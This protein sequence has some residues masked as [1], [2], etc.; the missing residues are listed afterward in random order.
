MQRKILTSE[1]EFLDMWSNYMSPV[2]AHTQ[3]LITETTSS[4]LAGRPAYN[5]QPSADTSDK[6]TNW[7]RYILQ[8]LQ[9]TRSGNYNVNSKQEAE[10]IMSTANKKQRLQC[11]QLDSLTRWNISRYIIYHD[12]PTIRRYKTRWKYVYLISL[13][14]REKDF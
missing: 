3:T 12:L 2:W 4:T 14:K 5:I 13:Y 7:P 10:T 8:T 6:H 11:Q 1:D 9:Q